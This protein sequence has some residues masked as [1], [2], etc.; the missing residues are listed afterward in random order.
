MFSTIQVNFISFMLC[1]FCLVSL[2]YKCGDYTYATSNVCESN[3]DEIE[4][5]NDHV[6]FEVYQKCSKLKVKL[7]RMRNE[8]SLLKIE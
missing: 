4:V 3:F 7:R 8:V 6:T 1:Y 2:G 5:A